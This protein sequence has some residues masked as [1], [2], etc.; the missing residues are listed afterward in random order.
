MEKKS[1]EELMKEL[2]QIV[3]ELENKDISLDD[4]VKKYQRGIELA[5]LCHTMLKEAESVIV[6]EVNEQ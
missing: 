5:N 3:K 4:A 1:F 2:E 6:K